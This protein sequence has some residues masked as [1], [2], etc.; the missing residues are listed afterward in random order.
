MSNVA[1]LRKLLEHGNGREI[2][3]PETAK[4]VVLSRLIPFR[5]LLCGHLR[6]CSSCDGHAGEGKH[7]EKCQVIAAHPSH[8]LL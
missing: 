5:K 3:L 7:K 6:V 4:G 2:E 8:H 1:Y